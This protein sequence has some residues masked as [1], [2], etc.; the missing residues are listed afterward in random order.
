MIAAMCSLNVS[1]VCQGEPIILC[2]LSLKGRQVRDYINVEGGCF[3][4][5]QTYTKGRGAGTSLSPTCA[6]KKKEGPSEDLVSISWME[7]IRE[8]HYPDDDQLHE[9]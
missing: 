2:S 3:S 6:A 1:T 4:G 5:A 9:V 7:L 8:V